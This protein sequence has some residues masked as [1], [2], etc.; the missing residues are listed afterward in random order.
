MKTTCTLF[1]ISLALFLGLI[2]S[3]GHVSSEPPVAVIQVKDPNAENLQFSM[4]TA[5]LEGASPNGIF[6]VL[7]GPKNSDSIKV[8]LKDGAWVIS[9]APDGAW[10]VEVTLL[11]ENHSKFLSVDTMAFIRERPFEVC[12]SNSTKGAWANY[13][14]GNLV[15]AAG[16]QRIALEARYLITQI[17]ASML[18]GTV[19]FS[20]MDDLKLRFDH[21]KYTYSSDTAFGYTQFYFIAKEDFGDYHAGDTITSN[22]TSVSSYIQ[23]ISLSVTDGTKWDKGPLYSIIN[24]SVEFSGKVPKFSLNTSKFTMV[25]ASR[26]VEVNERYESTLLTES[27]YLRIDTLT[28]D[29]LWLLSTISS[30][31]INEYKQALD[32][33]LTFTYENSIYRSKVDQLQ[34]NFQESML[35]L[36]SDESGN[37]QYRGNYKIAALKGDLQYYMNGKVSTTESEYT[38]F[39]CDANGKD[40]IGV[41]H[42]DKSLLY[43]WFVSPKGDSIPYGMVPF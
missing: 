37:G 43:G 2:W 19:N 15:L 3:C 18:L 39:T 32:S 27:P 4:D 26:H 31:T 25:L 28:S 8:E 14:D 12:G 9:H 1:K 22:L 36:Y 20:K 17:G 40:T 6:R 38:V 7:K 23:G 16:N 11:D 33:G 5:A 29:S 42:H 24:G 34:Q 30:M 13:L 35:Q 10:L 21:G 41:A